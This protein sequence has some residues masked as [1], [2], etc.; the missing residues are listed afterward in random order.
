MI[1]IIELLSTWAKNLVIFIIVISFL[2]MILPDGNIGKFV[3]ITIGLIIILVIINPFIKLVEGDIDIEKEVFK[4]IEKQYNYREEDQSEFTFN[5]DE[6]VKTLYLEEIKTGIENNII[7]K[8]KY[9]LLTSNIEINEDKN[10]E[11]YG[12]IKSLELTLIEDVDTKE[13][14]QDKPESISNID[15]I[16]IDVNIE[17]KIENKKDTHLKDPLDKTKDL[18]EIED[19]KTD[20]S[21]Q[22]EVPKDKIFINLETKE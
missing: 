9:S 18:K 17:T 22:F 11:N 2:E 15:D 1:K 13:N 5:Q 4:N 8:T 6:Q 20:L 14:D 7:S 3:K 12:M 16:K 19:I 10:S 21:K